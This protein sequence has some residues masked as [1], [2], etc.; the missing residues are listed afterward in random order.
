[1]LG[2]GCV[3]LNGLIS[4]FVLNFKFEFLFE[5]LLL[6]VK[7]SEGRVPPKDRLFNKPYM[8]PPSV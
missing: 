4:E 8:Y 3:K 1:M 5:G 6:N 2:N 7:R